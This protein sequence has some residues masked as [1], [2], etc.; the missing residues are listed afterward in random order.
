MYDLDRAAH[1]LKQESCTSVFCGKGVTYIGRNRG[2]YDLVGL[3]TSGVELKGFSAADLVVGKAAALLLILAGV[4]EVYT[5]VM[6]EPAA[7]LFTYYGVL[8]KYDYI[9]P[10]ILNEARTETCLLDQCISHTK[11]PEAALQLIKNA[12]RN[13]ESM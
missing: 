7:Y 3:L 4:K 1:L 8:S 13:I 2:V 9:V 10:E 6:S 12:L 5:P 11:S